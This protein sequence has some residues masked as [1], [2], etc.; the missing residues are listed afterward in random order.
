MYQFRSRKI[1][2]TLHT[3]Y[4]LRI[5]LQA[6]AAKG[7]RLSIAGVAEQH[8]ISRNHAMKVVNTLANAGLLATTRGRGGGFVLAREPKDITLGEVVRLT[9]PD[10]RPA[11]CADCS[12]RFGCGITPILA[13]A[14]QAFLDTLDR[15]TLADALAGST[16]PIPAP[17][18]VD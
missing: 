8:G 12:L 3:D 9:E 13:A 11:N 1:R 4:A 2:L 7:E 18:P 6:A 14:M 15:Q 10:V 16:F 17:D 5:L